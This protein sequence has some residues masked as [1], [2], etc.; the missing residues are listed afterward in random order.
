MIDVT[1]QDVLDAM[2]VDGDPNSGK[3]ADHIIS[4][5]LRAAHARLQ[6]ITHRIFTAT[7]NVTRT[8]STNGQAII[9]IT[10]CR[11]IDSVTLSGGT[12]TLGS[13]VWALPDSNHPEMFTALQLRPVGSRDH[14]A[15]PDWFDTNKDSAL[16]WQ[17]SGGRVPND[18][19]LVQ[20]EG[21]DPYPEDFLQAKKVLAAWYTKRPDSLL[22]NV[23]QTPDGTVR[24]FSAEPPEVADFIQSW[25][26]GPVLTVVDT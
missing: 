9:E 23:Q 1:I 14:R 4:S 5:N 13:D 18:L 2:V 15:Y 19:V 20:D 3:Y 16:Y 21:W 22:A 25:R 11:A 6:R 17:Q 10:D 26:R 8:Y 24:D 12:R 7:D